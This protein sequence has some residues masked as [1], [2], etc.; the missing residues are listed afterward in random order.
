ME[1]SISHRTTSILIASAFLMI[2]LTAIVP[3]HAVIYSCHNL[4]AYNQPPHTLATYTFHPA[5]QP[6]DGY[7]YLDWSSATVDFSYTWYSSSYTL[8]V[9]VTN[10]NSVSVNYEFT[11]CFVY[12]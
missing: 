2:S 12:N 1:R 5:G 8:K 10:D 6:I 4:T 3:T 7:A 11:Y 9:F